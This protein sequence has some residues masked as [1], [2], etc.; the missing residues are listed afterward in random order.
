MAMSQLKQRSEEAFRIG[1]IR[2]YRIEEW[3]GG[4]F[5]PAHLFAGFETSVW[6][7]LAPG[8]AP[9]LCADGSCYSFIQ[10][11]VLDVDGKIVMF[12]TG[13]GNDKERPQAPPFSL[14]KTGFLDNLADAGFQPED[15]DIVVNSH[16]H[17][18]HVGWNTRW[19]DGVWRP[20]FPNARYVFSEAE[21]RFWDPA[22]STAISPGEPNQKNCYD[23]SIQPI[24]EAGL[25]DMVE[26]G[27]E[28][29][30]GLTLIAAPGHTPGQLILSAQS[31][32]ERALFV[33]DVVHH[34]AQILQADWNSAFCE[35]PEQARMTRTAVLG[36]AADTGARLVPAHFAGD[37]WVWVEREGDGFRPVY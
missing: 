8:L 19:V 22:T 17:I 20:T 34:P 1:G 31:M 28:L 7:K 14:L 30:P 11:W 35:D 9:H 32:G 10:S 3:Q 6:K 4:I 12:D 21:R 24:L 33:G 15:V 29:M 26:D 23:D 5:P 16:L 13:L 18:D 2:V 25:A 36:M 27:H 37:H